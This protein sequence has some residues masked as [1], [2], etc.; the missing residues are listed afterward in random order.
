MSHAKPMWETAAA[1]EHSTPSASASERRLAADGAAAAEHSTQSAAALERHLAADGAAATEHGEESANAFQRHV[2]A[3]PSLALLQ[4]TPPPTY[5]LNILRFWAA[6]RPVARICMATVADRRA[7]RGLRATWAIHYMTQLS[8]H[9]LASC[10]GCGQYPTYRTC[11]GCHLAWCDDCHAW[12]PLCWKC[13]RPRQELQ[14]C[15]EFVPGH[16]G[17]GGNGR[18]EK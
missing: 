14:D 2:P 15:G 17:P 18:F 8:R 12:S 9:D 3:R 1:T 5:E 6:S 7:C 13:Y 10:R 16:G 4:S 11:T